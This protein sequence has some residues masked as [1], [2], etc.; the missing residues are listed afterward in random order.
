MKK[1]V[2]ACAVTVICAAV[3]IPAAVNAQQAPQGNGNAATMERLDQDSKNLDASIKDIGTKIQS[4]IQKNRMMELKDIKVIPYQTDYQLGSD[5]ILIE[6]HIF[7]RDGNDKIIGEKRKTVKFFVSGGNLSKLEST[8]YERDYSSS[9]ETIVVVTD[10]SPIGDNKDSITIR[11]T[12]NK[13]VVIDNKPLT[14][15]KNT[16]AFPVR[17]DFKRSFYIPHLIYF[18]DMIQG[19]AETYNKSSKDSDA[20]VTEFLLNS[21]RY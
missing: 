7:I 10:S 19:I 1:F 6:R 2:L 13:K 11:Q 17:N 18:Y 3:L 14:E 16:T 9:A 8:I 4:V 20:S 12:V 5:F 21:T 15:V